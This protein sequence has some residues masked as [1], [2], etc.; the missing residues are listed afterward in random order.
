MSREGSE[1]KKVLIPSPPS[2]F[3]R[4]NLFYESLRI[5]KRYDMA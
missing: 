5:D 2:R 3:S 4:D 1:G